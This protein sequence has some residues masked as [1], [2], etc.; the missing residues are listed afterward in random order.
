MITHP[1]YHSKQE[2]L[3]TGAKKGIGSCGFGSGSH[4]CR[5]IVLEDK[6]QLG[7]YKCFFNRTTPSRHSPHIVRANLNSQKCCYLGSLIS[8]CLLAPLPYVVL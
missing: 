6:I 2:L 1:V 8:C 7:K 4:P 3:M 5:T